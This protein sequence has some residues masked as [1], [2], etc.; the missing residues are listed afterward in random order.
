MWDLMGQQ[1]C[2][3]VKQQM[4]PKQGN[5]NARMAH[6]EVRFSPVTLHP[7][8]QRKSEAPVSC[9]AVYLK[10][11]GTVPQDEK[12]VEWMLLTT[13]PTTSLEEAC[14]RSDW[15]AVRW[16]IEVFHRTL[17]SGCKIE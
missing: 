5:R 10:E 6:L 15:Y 16:G 4:C 14:T 13:V 9:W 11:C 7:P 17:K 1:P 3:G 2:A 8:G 12:P